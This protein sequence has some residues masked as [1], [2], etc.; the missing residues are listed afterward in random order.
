MVLFTVLTLVVLPALVKLVI[1]SAMVALVALPTEVALM[2]LTTMMALVILSILMALL[3]SPRLQ[4]NSC[5]LKGALKI[6]H[7]RYHREATF[8]TDTSGQ[9][10]FSNRFSVIDYQEL[11]I[12]N[13]LAV[14][15]F[16]EME[17]NCFHC[18]HGYLILYCLFE[19]NIH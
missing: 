3:A 5:S 13:N 14:H 18:R 4:S 19:L 17:L 10:S 7:R 9:L 16:Y 11:H 15:L 6:R 1:R 12:T 8:L 2:V